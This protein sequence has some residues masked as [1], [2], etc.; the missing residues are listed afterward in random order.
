MTLAQ[1]CERYPLVPA[2]IV[3]WAL[4]NIPD[5]RDAERGLKRLEQSRRMEIKYSA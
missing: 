4:E 5:L 3:Q 2:E 1:A